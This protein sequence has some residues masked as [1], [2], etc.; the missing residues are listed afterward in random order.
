M[1]TVSGMT[2]LI[3]SFEEGGFSIKHECF[4][5]LFQYTKGVMLL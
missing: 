2:K 4:S 5:Y 3:L 1:D